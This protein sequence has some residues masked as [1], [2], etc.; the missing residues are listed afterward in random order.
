VR[1]YTSPPRRGGAWVPTRPG[2]LADGQPK[3]AQ[4]GSIGPD[5]GYAYRLARHLEDRLE[6]GGVHRDDAVAG[7]GAVATRRSALFGRAPVIHDLTASFTLF[8]FLDG[9]PPQELVEL[10]EKLFAQVR[11]AHHYPELRQLVELVPE[12][13]LAQ[14][15]D[16]I[17][18]NYKA[19]WRSNLTAA[20]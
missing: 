20:S 11:S 8:G 1:V 12:S 13:V 9:A 2:D 4:L 5:Q 16:T 7:C 10:R 6:L 18:A 14:P 15:H 17:A 19:N 3:G